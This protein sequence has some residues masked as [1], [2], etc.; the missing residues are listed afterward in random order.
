MHTHSQLLWQHAQPW[1]SSSLIDPSTEVDRGWAQNPTASELGASDSCWGKESVLFM[2]GSLLGSCTRATATPKTSHSQD[3]LSDTNWILW[4]EGERK[5]IIIPSGVGRNG[6]ADK[7]WTCSKHIVWNSPKIKY[8]LKGKVSS[9]ETKVL[10]LL[11]LLCRAC[12]QWMWH[13]VLR[14]FMYGITQP[15]LLYHVTAC[16]LWFF[17]FLTAFWSLCFVLSFKTR[18]TKYSQ[19]LFYLCESLIS[20]MTFFVFK[21]VLTVPRFILS[22]SINMPHSIQVRL[23]CNSLCSAM[24]LL[25]YGYTWDACHAVSLPKS[26]YLFL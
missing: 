20:C 24:C 26:N 22:L 8:C 17:C 16:F 6:R 1:A 21:V 15:A 12:A 10:L 19:L 25:F 5:E 13:L 7:R 23:E 2:M 3:Q 11:L 18:T 14:Q 9:T 4:G